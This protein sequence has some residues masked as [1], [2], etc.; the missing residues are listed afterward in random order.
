[1]KAMAYTTA[2]QN[3]AKTMENV[4]KD[5]APANKQMVSKFYS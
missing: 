1:M 2:R 5:H 3:H 4:C